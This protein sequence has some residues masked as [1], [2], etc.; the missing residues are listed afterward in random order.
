MTPKTILLATAFLLLCDSLCPA[1]ASFTDG[2]DLTTTKAPWTMRI[3][4]NDLDIANVQV[5]PDEQSAYFMMNSKGSELNVSVFI[6]PADKCKTSEACRDYVLDLGNPAW[7]KFQDLAKS[8]IRDF[9]YFEFYRPEAMGKPLKMF[10]MYAQ[11]VDQGYWVD[12]HI[13]KA[14]YTK[15]DHALFEKVINSI[16]F[17][18]KSGAKPAAFD[19]QKADG[20]KDAGTWLAIWGKPKCRESYLGLSSMTRA[21]IGEKLWIDYCEKANGSLGAN[22]SRKLVASAFTKSYPPKVASPVA[23]LAYHSNFANQA[24]V[25]ELLALMLEKDGKW[26]VTNYLTR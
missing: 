3:L 4:G 20:E 18:P 23:I 1:Q 25:V 9:H 14:L 11:Y 21:D 5:K 17:V 2:V 7:G 13:S 22:S 10:D 12:L 26:T 6:E 15:A 8:K 19:T 24:S 16:S